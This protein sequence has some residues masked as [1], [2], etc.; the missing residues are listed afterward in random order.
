MQYDTEEGQI[1][2]YN[3][4]CLIKDAGQDNRVTVLCYGDSNTYGY[5]PANGMRY[6]ESVRWTGRLQKL[7]TS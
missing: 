5:N 2:E 1:M 3:G 6:P 7:L 4:G